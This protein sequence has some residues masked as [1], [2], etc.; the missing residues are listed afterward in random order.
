MDKTNRKITEKDTLD[1][2]L[3]RLSGASLEEVAKAFGVSKQ[4]VQ[5]HESK[6]RTRELRAII[7]QRAAEEAGT[8][9]GRSACARLSE[10]NVDDEHEDIE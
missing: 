1:I 9:L 4:A 7:L 8:A 5:Y 2:I 10:F 3:M 6:K